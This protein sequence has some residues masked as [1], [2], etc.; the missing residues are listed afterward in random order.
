M[1]EAAE[2]LHTIRAGMEQL[3]SATRDLDDGLARLK[4][5]N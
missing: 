2:S 4:L 5:I 1:K 3:E